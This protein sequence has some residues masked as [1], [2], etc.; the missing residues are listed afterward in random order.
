MYDRL[1]DAINFR[2]KVS[3][4]ALDPAFHERVADI[5]QKFHDTKTYKDDNYFI[6]P[7][8]WTL[9]K[10]MKQELKDH[11]EAVHDAIDD[12][13]RKDMETHSKIVADAAEAS[14]RG[15]SYDQVKSEEVTDYFTRY[16]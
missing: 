7:K 2:R 13:A 15:V 14:S 4:Y 6:D 8:S 16:N 5:K 12:F 1:E 11:V 9:E 10:A 3:I